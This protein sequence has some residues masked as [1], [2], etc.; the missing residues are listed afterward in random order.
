M[1]KISPKI[2]LVKV[3]QTDRPAVLVKPLT[4]RQTGTYLCV[5]LTNVK[6][7]W[8]QGTNFESCWALS[9]NL[10]SVKRKVSMLKWKFL[11]LSLA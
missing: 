4:P 2:D 11:Y 9:A 6:T 3:G 7:D 1:L 8:N 5:K 10:P